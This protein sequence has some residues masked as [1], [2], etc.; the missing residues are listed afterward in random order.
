MLVSAVAVLPQSLRDELSSLPVGLSVL[1]S[2]W[3]LSV[4]V[5]CP[6]LRVWPLCWPTCLVVVSKF[7]GCAGGTLCVPVAQ[8]VCFVLAPD[9][10][11]QMVV[12]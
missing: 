1:Q 5:S 8:V 10:L 9:V 3:A 2:A 7:L 6:W 12:W 4:K 11:S